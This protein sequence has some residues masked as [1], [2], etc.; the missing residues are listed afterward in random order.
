M[1]GA[2][3]PM[4]A[5]WS[6]YPSTFAWAPTI[7]KSPSGYPSQP[8]KFLTNSVWLTLVSHQSEPSHRRHTKHLQMPRV[9]GKHQTESWSYQSSIGRWQCSDIL[10]VSLRRPTCTV[11]CRHERPEREELQKRVELLHRHWSKDREYL[12]PP[13]SGQLADLDPALIVSPP[14]GLEIG[15][16][17]IVTRQE[18]SDRKTK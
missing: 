3:K 7:N 14:P 9:V 1:C 11:E 13:A 17:P 5:T 2:M 15:Y 12:A 16:V 10:L 8:L 4:A 6:Y 18:P